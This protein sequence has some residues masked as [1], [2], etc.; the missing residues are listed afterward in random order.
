MKPKSALSRIVIVAVVLIVL[1]VAAVGIIGRKVY[2]DLI[3][4]GYTESARS[5]LTLVGDLIE[6]D[7]QIEQESGEMLFAPTDFSYLLSRMTKVFGFKYMYVIDPDAEAGKIRY[8]VAAANDPDQNEIISNEL[9]GSETAREIRDDIDRAADGEFAGPDHY[10]NEF[11][12]V[13][14][15]YY[16]VNMPDY[17]H[18]LVLGAD[19]DFSDAMSTVN[20][21]TL[22]SMAVTFVVISAV[23]VLLLIK[24]YKKLLRPV[25]SIADEMKCFE[26][27]AER[28]PMRLNAYREVEDIHES[29]GEM[30]DNIRG[31]IDK[32][33]TMDRERTQ[34][35]TE[36]NVARRIQ[37]GMVPRRF[38]L[39]RDSFEVFAAGEPAREV[40]GDFYDCFEQG[41]RVCAVVGD[42]S[43]KGIAAA[44]F[45]T[46]SRNLI[47][48]KLRSGLSPA[49]SLNLVNDELVAENPESM[50]V[51]VLA[52]SLDKRTGELRYANAGHTRP[53]LI[54]RDGKRVIKPRAATALGIFEDAC[55]EDEM[56]ML[57]DGEGIVI[58]SDGV[59]EAVGRDRKM[60]GMDRFVS[61]A[62][63]DGAKQCAEAVLGAVSDF[64]QGCD[65]SDDITLLTLFYKQ[66]GERALLETEPKLSAVSEMRK[67]LISLAG[68]GKSVRKVILCCEELLV[69]VVSYSGTEHISL[70]A[71]KQGS[72]VTL[73]FEDEGTPFDPTTAQ[74][75]QKDFRD[76]DKGGM[77]ITLVRHIAASI[78]YER[79]GEKN[80]TILT[81]DL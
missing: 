37:S 46:M 67:M 77:G 71:A 25:K 56:L 16:P 13:I 15:Y 74:V 47:R 36:L 9:P 57:H 63:T 3:I 11:G 5:A 49:Q 14:S 28:K 6:G 78:E 23:F 10:D 81:F 42:V 27:E 35:A 32:I 69:N 24:L 41:D 4:S 45:M 26:P 2:Y 66:S 60:F 12:E 34:A 79:I 73:R 18:S 7:A 29:F 53:L 30:S 65:R 48:E 1:G 62:T 64:A 61:A 19:F 75:K 51:T 58:Y 20:R 44:L 76:M 68:N 22:I 55:V 40:G 31:Y 70:L 80:V 54:T 39:C 33:R 21:Y 72:R 43:G 38:E 52:V 59:T 17:D 8:V 50:F